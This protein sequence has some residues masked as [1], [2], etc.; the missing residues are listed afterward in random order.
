MIV[1]FFIKSFYGGGA[2]KVVVN[3]A[4]ALSKRYAVKIFVAQNDGV[5]KNLVGSSIEVIELGQP[6]IRSIVTELPKLH[7]EHKFDV[8][9]S[10]LVHENIFASL[11]WLF[12]FRGFKLIKVEHNKV[13]DEMAAASK[14]KA[15]ITKALWALTK[16]LGTLTIGVS[17]GVCDDLTTNGVRRVRYIYNPILDARSRSRDRGVKAG[18]KILFVGRLVDQKDPLLALKV[19][20]EILKKDSRFSLTIAGEGP[21]KSEILEFV[22]ANKMGDAV[23][24]VG[25][26]KDIETLYENHDFL[27]LTSKF[28]GFGNVI[29]E[30]AHRG[31]IPIVAD[32]PFGPNEI[33]TSSKIGVLVNSRD[34]IG[35]YVDAMLSKSSAFDFEFAQKELRQRFGIESISDQYSEL[36]EELV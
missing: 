16:N 25:F 8:L 36:I 30:A 28:E 3:L 12:S 29:V 35:A 19:V 24:L 18:H 17:K 9:I 31:C 21:L 6:S 15:F 1:A 27:V 22:Q 26:Q 11:G 32:V 2:E 4:N 13:F 23:K 20:R 5:Y 10:N 34:N 33:V 14:A 7:K